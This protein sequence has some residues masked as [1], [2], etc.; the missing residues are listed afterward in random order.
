M[1]NTPTNGAGGT[2]SPHH[3][4]GSN[5]QQQMNNGNSRF[6]GK[7]DDTTNNEKYFGLENVCC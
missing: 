6:V 7:F 5:G 4:G 3:H 2:P 1:G